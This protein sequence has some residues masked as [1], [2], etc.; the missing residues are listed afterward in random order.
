MD[1]MLIERLNE[2]GKQK[3]N[4]NVERRLQIEGK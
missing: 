1:E 4:Q 3:F 2:L